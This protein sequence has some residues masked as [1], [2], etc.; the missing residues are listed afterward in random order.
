MDA[1]KESPR[2]PFG[3]QELASTAQE[4]S[5]EGLASHQFSPLANL[6]HHLPTPTT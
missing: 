5:K 3:N 1:S 6:I 2:S 4:P